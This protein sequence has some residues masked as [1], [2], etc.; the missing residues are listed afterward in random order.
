MSTPWPKLLQHIREGY[1]L[2]WDGTHGAVHWARV[3]ENGLRL[4]ET[5]GA[6]IAVVKLFAVFHDAR[7]V[8]EDHDPGHG[9]RGAQLAQA[10]R[11]KLFE[12]PD[13]DFALLYKACAEH[14]DGK[15]QGDVS[16]QTCWDA[17]RLDLS[18]VGIRPRAEFLCTVA[19]QD[20]AMIAWAVGRGMR[21]DAPIDVLREWGLDPCGDPLS[22]AA[23]N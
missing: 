17:D 15:T 9:T 6:N 3:W 2:P 23:V 7:R 20:S 1:E 12:L 13:R 22:A 4:A 5:T 10:L 16:V 19:A 8:N 11:G 18:R 14:T 21:D